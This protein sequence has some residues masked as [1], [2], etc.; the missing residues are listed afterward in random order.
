MSILSPP[1]YAGYENPLVGER[2]PSSSSFWTPTSLRIG[3]EDGWAR[4]TG[5]DYLAVS[6]SGFDLISANMVKVIFIF[7]ATVIALPVFIIQGNVRWGPAAL[8]AIG[9]SIGG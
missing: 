4:T 1:F 3:P 9:L 5:K 8:L 7:F 6:R 2:Q